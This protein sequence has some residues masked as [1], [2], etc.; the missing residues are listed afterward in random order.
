MEEL[1]KIEFGIVGY[2]WSNL[3]NN[4]VPDEQMSMSFN[5]TGYDSFLPET[6]VDFF[7][8]KTGFFSILGV[9]FPAVTGVFAGINM[10]GDLRHPSRSIPTGSFA[11]LGVR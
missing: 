10:S 11:A 4:M 5:S 8:D 7:S 1:L 9:F 3:L 2:N 6:T